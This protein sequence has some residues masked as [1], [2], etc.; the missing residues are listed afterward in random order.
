ME[1]KNRGYHR[2]SDLAARTV[3]KKKL[4]GSKENTARNE[5]QEAYGRGSEDKVG[6]EEAEKNIVTPI[7]E[8][9]R[10]LGPRGI[11][12]LAIQAKYHQKRNAEE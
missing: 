6:Q 4:C 2:S 9:W 1:E 8:H 10:H 12:T 3:E 5:I 7:A 11:L